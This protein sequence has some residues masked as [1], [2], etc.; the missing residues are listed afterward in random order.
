MGLSATRASHLGQ[1]YDHDPFLVESLI[2][3]VGGG[4]GAGDA[5]IAIAT[6]SHLA[7]LEDGLA[8]RSLD[9]AGARA[10]GRYLTLDVEETLTKIRLAGGP[11]PERFARVIG[12]L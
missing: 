12:D 10:A 6:R 2:R 3:C 9:L 4:L 11:D 7:E 8:S 1:I 5:V